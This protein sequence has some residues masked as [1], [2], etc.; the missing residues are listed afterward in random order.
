MSHQIQVINLK[1]S[2]GLELQVSNLGATIISLMV[3]DKNKEFV[4]VVVGLESAEDYT[5]QFYIEKGL[6]LGSS[7]GRYAGRISRGSFK[8]NN[9]V[10]PI[11]LDL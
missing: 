6:Y 5:K 10:Y 8:I 11:H 7:I 4:N 3:P 1:N 9:E 2:N